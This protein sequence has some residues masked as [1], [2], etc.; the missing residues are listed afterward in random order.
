MK[1]LI[2]FLF[3]IC[4]IPALATTWYVN[5]TGGTRYSTNE[6]SGQCN[7]QSPA[8]YP[9][10]GI[11]QNCA[12]GDIRYL[13]ADGSYASGST[14]PAWG[15]VGAGGDTYLINCPTDC[16]VGWSG[17]N[18]V[19]G[20]TGDFLGV[21]GNPF[22]SGAPA[23]QNG[24]AGAHTQIFGLNYA[25]CTA[26]TAKAHINGGYGVNS[27]FN[28]VG[29]T[30]VDIACF[31]ITDHSSCGRAGQVN[32]CSTSDPLSDYAESGIKTNNTTTNVT[33]TD[34]RV[35]GMAVN[36]M[37]GAT[38]TGVSLLRVA[39][40]GNASSGWDMDDG[41]GT[42]G[43]G[44]L[45]MN[46]FS[47]LW[48]GCAEEYPIV[49]PVP[50]QDCTDD[51]VGGYGDGI[52]TATTTSSPAW[53][54]NVSNSTAA[55]NTQDGFDLLHLRGGG[56]TLTITNSL[57]Y[58][59]MGQ[60]LKVGAASTARN[61]LLV[62]NCNALR[63]AI[64]GT[65]SGYNSRLSDF[66]RAA[67][68]AVVINVQDS[69][70][71]TYQ[72]NT[73]FSANDTGVE[74]DCNS[75]T[76][77]TSLSTIDFQDNLFFGFMNNAANGNPA[78]SQ[79]LANQI[80]LSVPGLFSNPGSENSYNATYHGRAECPKTADNETNAVCADPQLVDETWHVYGFGN[81]A[82]AEG[83]RVIGVGITIPGVTV[84]YAGNT[85]PDPPSIGA[86]EYGSTPSE[87]Q[88]TVDAAPNPAILDEQVILT[89]TV[90]QTGS[91]VPT[92][93]IDFM[94][95][96]D[97]LGQ[98][99]LDSTGEATLVIS[100]LPVGSYAVVAAYSGDSNYPSGESGVVPL[101]VFSATTTGLVASPNPVPAG[102]A[103]ALT[104][105]V[106]G[107]G[108]TAPAGTVS[109]LNGSTSLGTATLNASGVATLSTA[110]LAAGT[111]SLTAQYSGNA[112]FLSCTSAAVSVTVNASTKTTNTSL[113]ASPNPVTSGQALALTATVTG[114]G[115]TGT[116]TFLNG[117]TPLGTATLN[118]SGVA[119]LSNASLGAGTYSLTA[120]YSGSTSFLSSTSAAV[121]VTVNTEAATIDRSFSLNVSGSTSQ[122]VPS[123][124]TAAYTLDVTPAVG[125]T[126]PA[127]NFEVSGLPA[128]A[129]ATFSPQTIP[130]GNGAT[131]STLSIQTSVQSAML[132]R[133]GKLGGGLVV[134]LGVLLLPFGG[135]IRRSGK[136][137][138]RLSYLVLLLTGA[139]S[140]A[141]LTGCAVVNGQGEFHSASAQTYTVTV[142]ST[143]ASLSQ[144]TTVT[145]I[146]E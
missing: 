51:N 108:S 118:A 45:S 57:S 76:T 112:S 82:P 61:N 46:Y 50:Y 81:M 109:F 114:S 127:I 104:A 38:G 62:G 6:T 107:S 54:V 39:L 113:T 44:T 20:P 106:Q 116:V 21:A 124:G 142:T 11:N 89:A 3:L 65:P 119:T 133:N 19:S 26:D 67:D 72:F 13:W 95:G 27:V 102:Q 29:A 10:S 49:D 24:T 58:G 92:G 145:L 97:S 70:P 1:R 15:W 75:Q 35:H 69:L 60:Q 30:Y 91:A 63:Q 68:T 136:R 59:N 79:E 85:R 31:T 139:V 94:N 98:A 140:L 135:G 48:N 137:M 66:C 143:A 100:T 78:G 138:L 115:A 36:G 40:V 110:S 4:T 25:N 88:I 86:L 28:L 125:T 144:T 129:T 131:N 52:G 128:G 122:T 132:E 121:P 47:V 23:P 123:G 103:L 84:D 22:G 17:P 34:V 141:G 37:L 43:T 32:S 33:I 7:G 2:L 93:S 146:V 9:G 18:E 130:E 90:A 80:Y 77:C 53:I 55:Y 16:R 96:S 12:F 5:P 41:S 14:F 73:L 64:P 87:A 101:Q 83:S 71:T 117:P 120:Q 134:A 126:L 74:I 42:T 99:S 105:T 56:S 111:Y 8:A